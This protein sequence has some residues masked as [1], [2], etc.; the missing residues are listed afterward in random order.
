MR[1][2]AFAAL[3]ATAPAFGLPTMIRLGYP[4][5]VSCHIA[6]QGG[7]LLNLYGR[8]I[9][10]AQSMIGGEY[11][12]SQAA[13]F[14]TLNWDGRITQDLR[15]I[16]QQQDVSSDGKPGTQLFRSRFLYRN[17]TELGKGFRVTVTVTGENTS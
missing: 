6:P 16:L 3:I 4:N 1:S 9:D 7:G 8:S 13:L 14:R 10:Q 12:P 5:C 11:Q 17:A 2:I 15:T